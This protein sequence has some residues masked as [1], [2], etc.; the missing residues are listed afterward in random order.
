MSLPFRR[1]SEQV[2]ALLLV[3]ILLAAVSP[4]IAY[5]GFGVGNDEVHKG[6]GDEGGQ[7]S[8]DLNPDYL[9]EYVRT[10]NLADDRCLDVFFDWKKTTSGHWDSRV[11]RNCRDNA[12][13][14][15][16]NGW[17]EED[18]GQGTLEGAKKASGCIYY[19]DTET[20]DC[21]KM[22]GAT[23]NADNGNAWAYT[24]VEPDRFLQMWI[25]WADG[26]TATKS[27]GDA[28]DANN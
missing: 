9:H 5:A 13:R 12:W 22:S 3:A 19:Q 17:G 27:G 11:T 25:R 14:D 28:W 6:N 10:Y 26:G 20:Y 2:L 1:T 18:G 16:N 8:I 23:S 15:N 21:T 4:Q 24:E 7:W